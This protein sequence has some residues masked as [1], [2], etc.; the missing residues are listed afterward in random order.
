MS[1]PPNTTALRSG[2]CLAYACTFAATWSASSRVGVRISARTGWRAG[3]ALVFAC[4]SRRWM[5]GSEKLA[6]LPVPVCAA[7]MTSRPAS[8]TGM[9]CAWIGVGVV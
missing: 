2:V 3:D 9:A 1:T 6:V 4:G 8:T 5:I 7:P